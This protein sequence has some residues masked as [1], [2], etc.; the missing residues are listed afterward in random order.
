MKIIESYTNNP[1]LE[2]SIILIQSYYRGKKLRKELKLMKIK[3]N[4]KKKEENVSIYTNQVQPAFISQ[5][6]NSNDNKNNLKEIALTEITNEK[7][8][9]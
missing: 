5:I 7:L 6:Q 9:K 2:K 4:K 8:V 3:A 1:S